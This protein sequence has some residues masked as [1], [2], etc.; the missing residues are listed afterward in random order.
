MEPGK[1]AEFQSVWCNS[2][3]Y[4]G[5]AANFEV[6]L[7]KVRYDLLRLTEVI[8]SEADSWRQVLRWTT[9]SVPS[10]LSPPTT[11]KV[12]SKKLYNRKKSARAWKDDFGMSDFGLC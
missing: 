8:S 1:V 6:S 5:E 2:L 12:E 10:G 9:R 7:E 11:K 3:R 4:A